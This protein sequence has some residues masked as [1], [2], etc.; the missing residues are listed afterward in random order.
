MTCVERYDR[1]VLFRR[2]SKY[3]LSYFEDVPN[4]NTQF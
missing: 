1:R 3:L 2:L 4:G